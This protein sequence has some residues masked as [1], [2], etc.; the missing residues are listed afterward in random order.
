M[1]RQRPVLTP[2]LRLRGLEMGGKQAA[3]LQAAVIF[4]FFL[5]VFLGWGAYMGCR[6]VWE[7]FW[8]INLCESL[9]QQ[10]HTLHSLQL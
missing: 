8:C 1:G 10:A 3:R 7:A 6:T 9:Q 2:T 5:C 4:F